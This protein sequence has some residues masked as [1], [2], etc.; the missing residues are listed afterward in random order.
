MYPNELRSKLAQLKLT[1][2]AEGLEAQLSTSHAV[3]LSFEERFGLLVDY[4]LTYR[5]NRRLK[6]LL[7]MAKLKM[8]ADLADINFS[9]NRNI[10]RS[11]IATLATC[12]WITRGFNVLI[13][14]ATGTGKT[15]IACALGHQACLKGHTTQFHKFGLLLEDLKMA[16]ID[17]TFFARLKSVNRSSLLIVDDFGLKG[18]LTASECELFYELLDG[19]HEKGATVITSQLPQ[20]RWHEYLSMS[21]RT[22]AD[23]IMDRLITNASNFE[24]K[25]ESLRPRKSTLFD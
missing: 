8:Q 2:M 25:G 11:H 20:S 6:T 23:A 18:D 22:T 5:E 19:R 24:L 21:N 7:K 12:D 17:G 9:A 13:T 1:G 3:E 15:Y 4:E 10:N 14:G 16:R